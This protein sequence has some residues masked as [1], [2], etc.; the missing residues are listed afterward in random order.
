MQGKHILITGATNG[1]GLAAAQSLA[2]L[3]ARVA[4]VGRN[5]TRTRVAAAQIATKAK[6]A[7]VTTLVADLSSQAAVR[8]L[9]T[10]VLAR[11]PRLDVLINNAGA[12]YGTRQLSPDGIE[13]T[14][15]VNHLGPFLLTMLLLDRLKAS[16]P[17]RIITTASGAHQGARIPFDDVNAERSYRSFGRYGETKLANILFTAEL[18]RRLHGTGVT[19]NCYHPGLVATGFNR[20]NGLLTD[21][22]MT[23]LNL[24]ARTPAVGADTMVWLATSPDVANVSGNYF[25][26]RRQR[27]PG[28]EGQ[29]LEVARRLWALSEQQCGL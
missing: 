3:G 14:W 4:I 7:T 5:D 24:V 28:G 1:I 9:T 17:A 20:G 26:D 12:M 11:Y 10:E 6:G 19:A 2:A 27:M 23:A 18:A 13:L 22:G 29:D 16:A 21:I 25:F 15:A 8:K